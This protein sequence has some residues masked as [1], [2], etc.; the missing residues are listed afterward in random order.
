MIQ[1]TSVNTVKRI[2]HACPCQKVQADVSKFIMF[3]VLEGGSFIFERI[4]EQVDDK[5]SSYISLF[6]LLYIYNVTNTV[7]LSEQYSS[8]LV[9]ELFGFHQFS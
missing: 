1:D 5:Q 2:L 7:C 4:V 3:Q 6:S 8:P 9:F